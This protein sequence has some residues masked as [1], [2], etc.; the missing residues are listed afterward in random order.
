M[1]KV[2]MLVE[3][4]R[5]TSTDTAPR[6]AS[7]P[8]ALLQGFSKAC[9]PL[10][11]HV[12][13]CVRSGTQIPRNLPVN[14]HYHFLPVHKVGFLRTLHL[15]CYIATRSLLRVLQPDVLHAH[16]TE[17]WCAIVG[18]LLP[19]PKILTV[20]GYLNGINRV[21]PLRP[22]PHWVLQRLLEKIS[23]PKYESV[24]CLSDFME[25]S[26]RAK[27]RSTTLI[28]NA[29]RQEFFSSPLTPCVPGPKPLRLINIG[30]VYHL[31][32]QC[33]LVESLIRSPLAQYPVECVFLGC[34]DTTTQYGQRFIR[35]TNL[36]HSNLTLKHVNYL[37]VDGLIKLLDN[38]DCLVHVSKTESF[39][40][41][42]AEALVRCKSVFAFNAGGIPFVCRGFSKATLIPSGKWEELWLAVESW[43]KVKSLGLTSQ[44]SAKIR[45]LPK[46][47]AEHHLAA[48]A[49]FFSIN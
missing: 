8:L 34:L 48:Y 13:C 44:D 45:F 1:I 47:I 2:A 5:N 9:L 41:A 17:A 33:E 6:F 29:V 4:V 39:C 28:P 42:V 14:I 37:P 10:E 12:V 43:A 26:L 7:A 40:L 35:L 30:S 24:I 36:N 46:T 27:T 38:S 32:Q 11:I 16:G 20:H 23:I 19:F 22:W 31:K 49:K 18:A 25:A 3:D 15:G 21:A